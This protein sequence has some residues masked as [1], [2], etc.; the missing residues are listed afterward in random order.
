MERGSSADAHC[1]FVFWCVSIVQSVV[2]FAWAIRIISWGWQRALWSN[3][4]ITLTFTVYCCLCIWIYSFEP[5]CSQTVLRLCS[6]CLS[7]TCWTTLCFLQF[8]I[9]A[10]V[11]T[12]SSVFSL[13]L[14]YCH[15]P[16]SS[17][18]HCHFWTQSVKSTL[19]KPFFFWYSLPWGFDTFS[20]HF[21]PH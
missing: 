19:C 12:V 10:C 13:P 3:R 1:M 21:L 8:Q 18:S 15:N 11:S 16:V 17:L 14:L 5:N 4:K 20:V 2:N 7:L 6:L 9:Q